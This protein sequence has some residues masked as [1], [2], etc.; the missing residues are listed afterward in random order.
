MADPV[1]SEDRP[2]DVQFH[3]YRLIELPDDARQWASAWP[4]YAVVN[5]SR[6]YLPAASRFASTA[7]RNAA[8]SEAAA[9][10]SG[11]PLRDT[12]L[13]LGI[14]DG[15][16]PASLP[17][18]LA[19]FAQIWDGLRLNDDTPV[20]EL[21]DA[22]RRFNG[23]NQLAAEVLARRSDLDQLAI[24]FLWDPND[25][26]RA[27]GRYMVAQV[28]LEG[29]GILAAFQNRLEQLSDNQTGE[30][31]SITFVLQ[32]MGKAALY[33]LPDL[34]RAAERVKPCDYYAHKQLLALVESLRTMRD[35]NENTSS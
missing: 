23:P 35:A 9:R 34:E 1:S 20:E 31:Q 16:P 11:V 24:R 21:L 18:Q 32:K 22:A 13:R 15:N 8:L 5:G 6:V 33:V 12:L 25:K 10:Q 3:G 28:R 19:G 14:P 4:R 27:G 30:L 7:E 26:L 17:R 29:I 2:H